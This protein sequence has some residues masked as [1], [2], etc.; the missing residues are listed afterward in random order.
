MCNTMTDEFDAHFWCAARE[1]PGIPETDYNLGIIGDLARTYE[2]YL[3]YYVAVIRETV[4]NKIY[5]ANLATLSLWFNKRAFF[6]LLVD[7]RPDLLWQQEFMGDPVVTTPLDAAIY[8][9]DPSNVLFI[10]NMPPFRE[11]SRRNSQEYASI[12]RK[13]H[14]KALMWYDTPHTQHEEAILSR[15][16]EE[17]L[18]ITVS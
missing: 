9:R 6:T 8:T 10:L 12:I 2:A 3:P 18:T 4:E 11:F 5:Y 13:G 14:D 1:I 15:L 7:L 16:T 17:L